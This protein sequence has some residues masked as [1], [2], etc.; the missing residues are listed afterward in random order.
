MFAPS[1]YRIRFASG[2][3]AYAVRRLAGQGCRNPLGNRVLIGEIDGTPAAAVS[4]RT[5][6]VVADPSRPTDRLVASLSRRAAAIRG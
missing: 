5:G 4:I 1:T 2:E 6:R 3:D